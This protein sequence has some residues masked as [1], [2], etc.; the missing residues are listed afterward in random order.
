[1]PFCVLRRIS[2]NMLTIK[3]FSVIFIPRPFAIAGEV[4]GRHATRSNSNPV[5]VLSND[6]RGC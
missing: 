5:E 4:T 2:I 1:M 3:Y 6:L